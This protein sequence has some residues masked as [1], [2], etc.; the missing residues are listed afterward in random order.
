MAARCA[1]ITF[2]VR[3]SSLRR[4]G[5]FKSRVGSMSC[6]FALHIV[7]SVSKGLWIVSGSEVQTKKCE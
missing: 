4:D 5:T 3:E 7:R 2:G 6:S 1:S